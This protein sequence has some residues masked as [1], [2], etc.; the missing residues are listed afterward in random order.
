MPK[1]KVKWFD[2]VKGYGFITPDGEGKD[3]FVH[4]SNIQDEKLENEQEVE[5]EVV[6]GK[7]GPEAIE[8]KGA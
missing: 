4:I 2:S 6:D 1:G 7:K 8:V 3:L 5:F